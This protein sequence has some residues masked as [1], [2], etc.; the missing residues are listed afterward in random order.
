MKTAISI[1][2]DVF[3]AA[4]AAA[5]R[6]GMSRSQFFVEAVKQFLKTHGDRGVTELL[7]EV[8]GGAASTVDPVLLRMQWASTTTNEEW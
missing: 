2:N 7:N 5:R 4:E 3:E 8:H 1:P 6:T